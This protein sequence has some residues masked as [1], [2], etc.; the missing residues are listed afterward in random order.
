MDI[1]FYVIEDRYNMILSFINKILHPEIYYSL[2]SIKQI[3]EKT[4]KQIIINKDELKIYIDQFENVGLKLNKK[5]KLINHPIY[6]L[7]AVLKQIGYK[8]K[9]QKDYYGNINYSIVKHY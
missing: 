2:T 6:I 5:S 1:E 8:L 7:N 3:K 4:L 9:K